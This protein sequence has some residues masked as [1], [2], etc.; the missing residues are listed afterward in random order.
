MR[1]SRVIGGAAAF[2]VALGSTGGAVWLVAPEAWRERLGLGGAAEGEAQTGGGWGGAAQPAEP[3]PLIDFAAL[4]WMAWTPE[5][6]AFFLFILA[7]LATMTG[8]EF[9]NPGGNP[10]SG[11]LGLDTTRGDRLFISLLGTAYI[12]LAWLGLVGAPL[13]GAVAIAVLWFA[14][15]FWKV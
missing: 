13:W 5:T 10:R 8:M 2:L 1:A 9:V 14:F 3:A 6:G 4:G 12:M 11:I 7:C 15:V